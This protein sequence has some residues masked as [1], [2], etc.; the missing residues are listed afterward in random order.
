[1]KKSEAIFETISKAGKPMTPQEV[2]DSIKIEFPEF[3]ATDSHKR[4]VGKGTFNSLDHALLADVYTYVKKSDKFLIDQS[5]KPYKISLPNSEEASETVDEDVPEDLLKETGV[6][7]VLSTGVYTANGKRIIKIGFTTQELQTRINQLYTTGSP[8]KFELIKAYEV[9]NYM[10][11]EQALHKLLAPYRLSTSR[12]F[13]SE[14]VLE[15]V[16]SVVELHQKIQG[17][18]SKTKTMVIA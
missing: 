17:K 11:L 10:E 1:M 7:Y 3:Y 16:E 9:P 2:R 14:D 4:A 15:Y 18:L 6:V 5:T 8:F 12:E 13:F